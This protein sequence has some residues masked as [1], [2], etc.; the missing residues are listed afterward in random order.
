MVITRFLKLSVF[1]CLLSATLASRL[2][3]D[4]LTQLRSTQVLHVCADPDNLPFSSKDPHTPGYDVEMAR[5]IAAGLQARADL[6]WVSTVLGRSAIRQLLEGK[7]D[8]FMGLPHDERFLNDNPRLVL[9][10][11]YYTLRHLLV[12]PRA[13]PVQDL[14]ALQERKVAVEAMSL[15]DIFLFQNRQPRLPYRTP[16]EAFQA[17]VRGEAAVALLWAPH[18]W[19]L[20]KTHPEAQLYGAEVAAPNLEFKVGAGM[21]KGEVAFAHAVNTVVAQMLSAG[22][23]AAILAR[24]GQPATV[25]AQATPDPQQGRSLYYQVCAP[26]H[27]Q[28]AEGGGPVPNLKEFQGTV[29]RFVKGSLD[30]RPDRGMPP[31]KGKLSE[32][33]IR[34]ILAFIQTL[35]R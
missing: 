25:L 6:T 29:E 10:T 19:W 28:N 33:E 5:E 16:P 15:G 34:A 21:R 7:C 2:E 13:Q 11:P 27:G 22:K 23:V 17:V 8:L 1:I 9:S 4:L 3:A 18:G 30:G 35:P 32:D 12:S 14:R 26:C 20:V 31:W 24:Y